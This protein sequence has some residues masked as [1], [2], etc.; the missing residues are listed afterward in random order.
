MTKRISEKSVKLI[1]EHLNELNLVFPLN[2][3]DGGYKILKFF[4]QLDADIGELRLEGKVVSKD[5]IDDVG[6]II[7]EFVNP[8]DPIDYEDLEQRLKSA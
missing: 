2:D 3:E 8:V 5:L 1:K 7:T 4:E 6:Q